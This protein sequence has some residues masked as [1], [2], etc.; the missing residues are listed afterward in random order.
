[1]TFRHKN[2]AIIMDDGKGCVYKNGQ[3][4]FKGDGYIAIKFLLSYT[5]DAEEV[6]E[7]FGAQLSQRERCRWQKN[8]EKEQL[9]RKM[10][11]EAEKAK[12]AI[13]VSNSLRTKRRT[14]ST[15]EKL[16]R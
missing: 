6:K 1:M 3:L 16:T 7:Y 8:D 9:E 12:N 10:K 13:S 5:D 15:W 11:E 4:M 2:C 14:K